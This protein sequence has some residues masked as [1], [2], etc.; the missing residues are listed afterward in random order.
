MFAKIRFAFIYWLMWILVFE[1]SRLAFLLYNFQFSR[2]F[3]AGTLLKTFLYG[4]RM[5]ASMASYIIIIP[6]IF[7]LAAIFI[8]FFSNPVLYKM[9][10]AIILLPVLTIVFCDLPVYKAWGMRLDATPLKYLASPKEAWA[11]I[12]NL[13]IFWI[14]FFFL[15][16]YLLIYQFFNRFIK[17]NIPAA[18]NNKN[19]FLQLLFLLVFTGLQI[20]PLRGGLQLA[21]LNQSCVYFSRDNFINLS[22]INVPWNFMYTVSH[23]TASTENPFLYL[24]TTQAKKI[25]DS[26]FVQQGETEKIIDLSKTPSPNIIVI[27]WESFIEKGTH[28]SRD[29]H[30]VTPGFNELKKDGVYF[31]N[32]YCSGDRTDKGIVAVLSGYPAQ[33]ISS[34]IKIPQKAAKLPVLPKLFLDKKYHTSFY[35]GGELEFA[36]MKSYLLGSGFDHFTSKDDFDEKDQNSKWGAHDH[37]VKNKIL[38]DLTKTKQPFFTTWLTLSSHEPFET[39]V[40]T[41]IKGKDDES[42]FLNSLHYTDSSIYAF[43]QECK[44]QPWWN[45][46]I[47]IITADHGHRLP[48]T[49]KQIDDFKVPL[50]WLGG[51]L[52]KKGIDI[53]VTGSQ[54]DIAATLIAQCGMQNNPFVWSKDLLINGRPQWA[55]FSMSNAFGFVE[56]GKYFIYDNVGKIVMEQGGNITENDINKGKAIEQETFADY[57]NK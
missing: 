49:G 40:N 15:L 10:T 48:R 23:H 1:L 8:S 6:C 18:V 33:P 22:A 31:S 37:V 4:L 5:D 36:N 20:I 28:I 47:I 52:T 25:K 11:S 29:G 45:N 26:L 9:Y 43:V 14:F 57:L 42:L 12:S 13:P 27:V 50:L 44:Q 55:Y 56:P 54:T 3:P 51:A 32:I 16:S 39:P 38:Q 53:P 17:A 2:S 46:T 21:S 7:L 41:V 24:D 19:R 35:Y 30:E 34:I